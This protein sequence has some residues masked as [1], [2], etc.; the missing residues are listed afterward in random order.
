MSANAET[1]VCRPVTACVSFKTIA[2][3]RIGEQKHGDNSP[4]RGCS[5][6]YRTAFGVAGDLRLSDVLPRQALL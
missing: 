4:P 3:L 2:P 6:R 1:V 5:V